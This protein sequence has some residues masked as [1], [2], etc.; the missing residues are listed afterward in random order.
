M[1]DATSNLPVRGSGSSARLSALSAP[2][3]R[4]FTYGT[5]M[6]PEVLQV[7]LGRVPASCEASVD[8]WR[9]VAI[10]GVSYPALVPG[11]GRA[12]GRVLL[13]LRPAE[14]LILDAYED[15]IYDLRA[16]SV[17]PAEATAVAYVCLTGEGVTDVDW[18]RER[19]AAEE[20]AEFVPLCVRWRE[21]TFP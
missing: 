9:T 13:D 4:L 12:Q 21:L 14:W 11:L 8:G 5:L 16:V 2:P 20:L 3:E 6:F 1:R 15:V 18:D 17:S 19:F 7:L 10:P